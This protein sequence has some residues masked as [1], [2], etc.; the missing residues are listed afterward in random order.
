MSRREARMKESDNLETLGIDGAIM[1][2]NLQ[3]IGW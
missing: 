2:M 1:K 3:D